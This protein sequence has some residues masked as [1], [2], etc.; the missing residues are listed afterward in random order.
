MDTLSRL[1]GSEA[2]VKLMRLFLLNPDRQ[3]AFKDVVVWTKL[4]KKVA[5]NE[6]AL[7]Q[8][9]GLIL[10]VPIP[11]IGRKKDKGYTLNQRFMYLKQLQ[12]LIIDTVLLNEG[13]TV[14]RLAKAGK[15]K[16]IVVAGVFIQEWD[17]RADL[18]VVG[19]KIKEGALKTVIRKI[20]LELGRELRY[21]S[22]E[23]P[24]FQYRLSIGDR[25]VR[26]ILDYPHQIIFDK[27]GLKKGI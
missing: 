2:R 10:Q 13:D 6:L 20:E 17:S 8:K 19:D 25:L 12:S 16:L 15:M 7:L 11:T 5:Q 26:D 23:T 1:F 9:I 22:L 3:Y 27:F 4:S 21:A 24:D 18:L 14:K